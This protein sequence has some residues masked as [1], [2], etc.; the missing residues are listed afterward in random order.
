MES[1]IPL[2]YKL[3]FEPNLETF[4]FK[5]REIIEFICKNQTNKIKLNAIELQV[6]H[7]VIKNAGK[8]IASKKICFYEEKRELDILLKE[9]IKGKASIHIE[10]TGILNDK[11]VGFYLSHYKQKGK[12]VYLATTQFEAADARRAFPC[13]DEP[14]A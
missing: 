2:N 14:E 13:W 3:E 1:I 8:T 9:K 10:F 12:T 6:Q 7:C 11:M 5:G 4:T